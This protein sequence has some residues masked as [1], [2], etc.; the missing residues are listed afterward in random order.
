MNS[1]CSNGY[2][3]IEWV[4]AVSA[5]LLPALCNHDFCAGAS[6]AHHQLLRQRQHP[7]PHQ[8]AAQWPASILTRA[9]SLPVPAQNSN[10]QENGRLY[11]GFRRGIYMFPC[12]EV[13]CRR[14]LPTLETC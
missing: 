2:D 11:H 3:G 1:G 13:S 7:H 6:H 14:R 8:I 12:D 5:A 9:C 4:S 10:Y